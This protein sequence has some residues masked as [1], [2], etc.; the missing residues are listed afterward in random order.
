MFGD[1]PSAFGCALSGSQ[2]LLADILSDLLQ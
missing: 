2:A 1:T